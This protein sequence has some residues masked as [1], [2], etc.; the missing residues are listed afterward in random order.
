MLPESRVIAL[1]L[2]RR[3]YSVSSLHSNFRDG[4]RKTHVFWHRARN[5]PPRSYKI[6]DFGTNRK[7]V[8]DFLLVI[9]SDLG[10]ISP[11]FKDFASFLLRRA[12][13][14]LFHPNFRGLPLG[15]DWRCW[16]SRS[17]DPKLIIRVISFKLLQPICPRY[18]NVMDRRMDRRTEG[19]PG[20]RLTIA[21][22]R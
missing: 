1:R 3:Q 2:R 19:R 5:G 22:P 7:R 14:P 16:A 6:V 4:H 13:P 10:P 17:E 8:C 20:G 15:L 9:N 18:I 12:T 11:R 21:I